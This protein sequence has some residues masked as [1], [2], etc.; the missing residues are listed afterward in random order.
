VK[1]APFFAADE[2]ELR[3]KLRRYLSGLGERLASS[4]LAGEVHWL[5]LAGG[6]GRGEGGI[7]RAADGVAA[8][9]YNDLEFYLVLKNRRAR[10]AAAAWAAREAHQ[11]EQETG[12]EVVFKLLTFGELRGAEPSMFYYDLLAA[13]L[14]VVGDE[15]TLRVLP[16]SLRDGAKIPAHEATRLLFNRGTGLMF[17]GQAL[18]AGSERTADGFIERN[19]AKTR[20]ALADAVLAFNGRYH[21]SA[22]VRHERLAEPLAH[23]PPDWPRLVAWHAEGLEFKLRPRHEHPGAEV[24]ARRQTELLAVWVRTFL[25]LES[26]RL[27][28]RFAQAREYADY[29]RRL[30]P[31]SPIW[32]N[33]LLHARDRLRRGMRLRGWMDYPRA[34]LQRVLVLR[35]GGEGERSDVAR[36]LGLPDGAAEES[37]DDAY[38]RAWRFYN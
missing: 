22:A 19:H 29:A 15:N 17:C 26:L 14:L 5:L 10:P 28:Q 3:D 35:L 38:L 4:P 9:L 11:G 33:A 32:R 27:G 36:W 6:Y 23:V 1:R 8:T 34:A 7:F 24:L 31:A 21:F 16:A 20:L 13:H 18:G 37:V 25:W 12:L 30:F 2:P